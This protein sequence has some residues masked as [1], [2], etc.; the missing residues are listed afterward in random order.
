ME[1]T[2]RECT[3]S[4]WWGKS[5]QGKH[6]ISSKTFLTTSNGK[7]SQFPFAYTAKRVLVPGTVHGRRRHRGDDVRR[8]SLCGL[9]VCDQARLRYPGQPGVPRPRLLQRLRLA[10]LLIADGMFFVAVCNQIGHVATL[11]Y[12]KMKCMLHN[13]LTNVLDIT[14][15]A[16][17]R[18]RERGPWSPR[19][20]PFL[21][22][23]GFC[24]LPVRCLLK[25]H[26]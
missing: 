5:P 14:G 4:L 1:P 17:R 11:V 16:S 13:Q 21:Y 6:Y 18:A 3:T 7:S 12:P 10:L 2:S 9:S 24:S 22:S 19:L 20:C 26:W 25:L 15:P 23:S 8:V